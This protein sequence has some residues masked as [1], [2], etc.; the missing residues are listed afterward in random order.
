MKTITILSFF[1]LLTSISFGQTKNADNYLTFYEESNTAKYFK[2]GNSAYLDYYLADKVKFGDH[3]YYARIR[4]YSWG[5]TDTSYFRE[6]DQNYLHFDLKTNSES[7]V[8]PKQVELG[9]KWF[10]ADSSWSYEIIGID[11]KLETPAKKYK[12]LIVVECVQ[13]T[14]RDKLK[15]KVYHMYYAEGLGMVGSVNNGQLTSYLSEVKKG[16]KEGEKIGN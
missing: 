1:V 7:V 2:M 8:L 5:K 11:E 6:D 15:S 10:E 9:Q 16:A 3:E 12:G 14:G 13:L 4:K